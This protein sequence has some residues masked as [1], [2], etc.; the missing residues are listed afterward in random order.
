MNALIRERTKVSGVAD[1][2]SVGGWDLEDSRFNQVSNRRVARKTG[3]VTLRVWQTR[4][5][6]VQ[7]IECA[8]LR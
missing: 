7:L 5:D 6:S 1:Q 2:Q 4:S 3:Q 8:L